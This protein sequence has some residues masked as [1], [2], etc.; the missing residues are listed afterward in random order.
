MIS[1]I[2]VAKLV[3][4]TLGKTTIS[5]K[6]QFFFLSKKWQDLWKQNHG[7]EVEWQFFIK[8]ES[9]VTIILSRDHI[10]SCNPSEWSHILV[11]SNHKWWYEGNTS[12]LWLLCMYHNE[13]SPN[14]IIQIMVAT[15]HHTI[16][17]PCLLSCHAKCMLK[18]PWDFRVYNTW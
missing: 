18:Y 16:Y 6:S 8:I 17:Y 2:K 12:Y 4:F 5:I 15:S 9:V 1:S 14:L 11:L 13:K 3:E 10:H 7:S